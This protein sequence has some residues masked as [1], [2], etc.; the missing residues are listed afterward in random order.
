MG[1]AEDK[2]LVFG[3]Q[4]VIELIKSGRT[5]EKIFVQKG[6]K[7]AF[8]IEL[9]NLL[10]GKD[11]PVSMV[12]P[13]K[14]NKF[15]KGNHQGIIAF[16]AI[17]EYGEL[18]VLVPHVIESGKDP[19]FLFLDGVTDVRNFGAIIRTAEVFG[20]DA[21]IFPTKNSALINQVMIKTSAGALFHIPL[22]RVT[23]LNNAVQYLK[24]SGVRIL[25]SQLDSSNA[26]G[27]VSFTG[28]VCV[29]IGSE[30]EGISHHM[31]KLADE[32]FKIEQRGVTDS[33]NVSVAT[34]IILYEVGQQRRSSS[35]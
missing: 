19:L 6:L 28:P 24:D 3:R 33:L 32:S 20:V 31:E 16:A 1:F 30:D 34:G 8:E 9:R 26:I 15:T 7:G 4:P 18:E 29:V 17:V 23:S 10:K 27:D 5:V 13:M 22:V 35:K 14:L 2:Q 11:I 25:S 12:H 21:I